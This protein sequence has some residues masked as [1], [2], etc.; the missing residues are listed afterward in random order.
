MD[1]YTL[2]VATLQV[3]ILHRDQ[4]SPITWGSLRL[5]EWRSTHKGLEALCKI[6]IVLL[7]LPWATFSGMD[8]AQISNHHPSAPSGMTLC[9]ALPVR[10]T[11]TGKYKSCGPV[12]KQG[13]P[14]QLEVQKGPCISGPSRSCMTEAPS[15]NH[16]PIRAWLSF[17]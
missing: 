1:Y 11:T 7:Q 8:T 15:L 4:S 13:G 9:T 14:H 17:R 10:C 6:V 12:W 3:V 5:G 2:R 16:R